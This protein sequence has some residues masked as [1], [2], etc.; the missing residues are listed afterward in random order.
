[1][2]NIDL[3]VIDPDKIPKEKKKKLEE[4][5]GLASGKAHE[6]EL[7]I[8]AK[9]GEKPVGYMEVVPNPSKGTMMLQQARVGEEKRGK[10]IG[11]KMNKKALEVANKLGIKRINGISIDKEKTRKFWKKKGYEVKESGWMEKK[12]TSQKHSTTQEIQD[13]IEKRK[14]KNKKR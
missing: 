7:R 13:I 12:K 10:G 11:T 9:E 8:I 4:N 5:L 1:M 2:S 14:K 6:K 3:E